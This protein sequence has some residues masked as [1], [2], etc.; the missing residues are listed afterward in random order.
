MVLNKCVICGSDSEIKIRL[1]LIIIFFIL[2]FNYQI[3]YLQKRIQSRLMA[4]IIHIL[5]D[6]PFFKINHIFAICKI[7]IMHCQIIYLS[8][9]FSIS[10]KIQVHYSLEILGNPQKLIGET[11][12]CLD[13]ILKNESTYP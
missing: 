5:W 6:L 13:A 9:A 1:I 4:K 8:G 3:Y 12:Q 10:S 7:F 2:F 11:L